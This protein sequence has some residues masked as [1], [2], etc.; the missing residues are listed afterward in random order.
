MKFYISILIIFICCQ[1][2][3]QVSVQF[4]PEVYGRNLNGLFNCRL[5][6]L[7]GRR[8]ASLQITVSERKAGTVC[9]IKT[10]EFTIL[11]GSNPIPL[12]AASGAAIRFANNRLGQITASSRSFPEGDYDYCFTLSYTH[13]DNPPDE[14]CFPYLLAPFAD[15]SLIDPL[16]KDKIC[17]KRPL[18][19][20]QPLLPGLAGTNYQLVLAEIKT[21]QNA[22]EALNYNLPIINQSGIIA[23]ILPFP[24]VNR[25]LEPKKRYAWQVTAYKEHTILNRSEIWEFTLDCKDTVPKK[26]KKDSGYRDIEDLLKGNYYVAKGDIRISIINPYS[27]Q[28]LKYTVTALEGNGKPIGK[29]PKLQLENGTNKLIIDLSGNRSFKPGA[30]YILNL[31]LP[32]GGLKNL[33]FLYEKPIQ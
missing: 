8:T 17:D 27:K 11:P 24:A 30:Y 12:A 3:A 29:L 26:V 31:W 19:T 1:V 28:P 9:V 13:S 4:V 22:T 15:L 16:N 10:A 21:G 6:N 23:P 5:M 25:E 7:S 18:F 2:S 33:R 14:Q 32:N 20:W